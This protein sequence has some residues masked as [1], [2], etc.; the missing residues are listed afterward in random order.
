VELP[1]PPARSDPSR[2]TG[3]RMPPPARERPYFRT[4]RSDRATV[5]YR[6]ELNYPDGTGSTASRI[7]LH[8]GVRGRPSRTAATA[9]RSWRVSTTPCLEREC[10]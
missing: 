1:S 8:G 5:L 2:A 6:S 3:E 4:A 10:T 7:A 9:R